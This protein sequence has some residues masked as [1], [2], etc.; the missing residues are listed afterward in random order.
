VICKLPPRKLRNI[1]VKKRSIG[2]WC[3]HDATLT[4]AGRV[5]VSPP[6]ELAL[7]ELVPDSEVFESAFPEV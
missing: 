2:R 1:Q 6:S 7:S 3:F 4:D 5:F